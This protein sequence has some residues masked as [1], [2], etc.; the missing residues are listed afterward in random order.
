MKWKVV[1]PVV[2]C[3]IIAAA[4]AVPAIYRSLDER[5]QAA[6]DPIRMQHV[7]KIV[8][9]AKAYAEK[10]GYPPLHNLSTEHNQPF[11]VLIGRSNEE[12]EAFANVEALKKGAALINSRDFEKILSIGL[13]KNVVLPRDPQTVPTYAPN[14]YVYMVY[15]DQMCAA[16]HLFSPS[17]ISHP[18]TWEGGTFHSHAKCFAKQ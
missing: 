4:I 9:V 11:M 6:H 15:E 8:R 1:L 3:F 10:V 18:Y 5:Y 13:E 17:D 14:V 12:E 16:A 7:D 2:A